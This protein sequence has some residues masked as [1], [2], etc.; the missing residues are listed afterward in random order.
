M[1][2]DNPPERFPV[3]PASPGQPH[4]RVNDPRWI[5]GRRVETITPLGGYLDDAPS[6]DPTVDLE[7]SL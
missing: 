1:E 4:I 7:G 3:D 5:R 6:K 2:Q